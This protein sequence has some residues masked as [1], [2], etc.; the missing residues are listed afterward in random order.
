MN[1]DFNA[2]SRST[3]LAKT[4]ALLGAYY[5][6]TKKERVS[7]NWDFNEVRQYARKLAF[8]QRN[9][10]DTVLDHICAGL[11][12]YAVHTPHPSYFG[13]FNPRSNFASILGD[14]ITATFNPQ[15][16]AWSHAPFANEIER[17]VIEAFGKRMGFSEPVD[18]T[19]CTGGAEANLT[20]ILCALNRAFPHFNQ[21]GIRGI[22]V[23]PVIY[24]SSE[25]HHSIEKAAKITGLGTE[26]VK[27]IPV[28]AD[29]CMNL[30]ILKHQIAQDIQD[31]LF[32]LMIVGTAGTTGAG[33]I[34]D[35]NSL[36]AIA[37]EKNIWF[38]VDAAYGGAIAVSEKYK[39]VVSGIELSDSLTID[40]HKWFSVPMGASLLLTK[41][42]T[43]LHQSFS[44][45]TDYMPEDGDVDQV[46][47]PYVHSIQWSRRF[48]GLKIYL[49]LVIHG[50]EGYEQTINRQ[51]ELGKYLKNLLLVDGWEI[52]NQ[53]PLPILCFTAAESEADEMMHIVNNINATGKAWLSTYPVRGVHTARA[54]ITNYQTSTTELDHLMGLLNDSRN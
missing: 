2:I 10:I 32:P 45:K 12:D 24:C 39:S 37:Q 48:I 19:F 1:L 35:L 52:H 54:C 34:D 50:W 8:T 40:L 6:N 25:S 42:R 13:L 4:H 22:G 7:K 53:T 51:V 27:F 29:L 9:E 36:H 33:A 47:N 46:V 41:D 38:H 30:E 14:L 20:A 49:P 3:S 26:S 44:V 15:L 11:T 21:S 31:G 16:A 28:E 5:S 18:G 17:Y 23:Q 43:I